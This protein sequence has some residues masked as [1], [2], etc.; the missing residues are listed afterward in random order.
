ME[1]ATA[2]VAGYDS[3][4]PKKGERKFEGQVIA[5]N[6]RVPADLVDSFRV[7]CAINRQSMNERI[8][9]LI[10]D[11]IDFSKVPMPPE[12]PKARRR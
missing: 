11:D 4:M 8:N 2:G 9:H 5:F 6:V 7:W 1:I 12:P 3:V 10:R